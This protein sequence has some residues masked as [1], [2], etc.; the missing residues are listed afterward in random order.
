[1]KVP[2]VK[3]LNNDPN[4][5]RDSGER[6]GYHYLEETDFKDDKGQ[7]LLSKNN[8]ILI[9]KP[10]RP[11]MKTGYRY[12]K[13]DFFLGNLHVA[14][15]R[16]NVYYGIQYNPTTQSKN[17]SYWLMYL[18][19]K[20]P[21]ECKSVADALQQLK[22]FCGETEYYRLRREEVIETE[23]KEVEIKDI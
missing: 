14:S 8:L 3:A 22:D 19:S 2:I 15:I 11:K 20:T 12:R 23:I 21:G 7:K 1:M 4:P 16:E 9:K 5:K 10:H 18:D 17:T 6:G 13:I